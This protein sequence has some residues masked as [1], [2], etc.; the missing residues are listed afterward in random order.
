MVA[1][2]DKNMM[3]EQLFRDNILS[4]IYNNFAYYF[5]YENLYQYVIWLMVI[6]L[7]N[8]A[9]VKICFAGSY[10]SFIP[11]K[12]Y[13]FAGKNGKNML[14]F[15]LLAISLGAYCVCLFCTEK[16]IFSSFDSMSQDFVETM[17]QGTKA[18]F[19]EWRFTPLQAFDYN[20]MFGISNNY[21]VL[22]CYAVLKQVI[23]MGVLYKLLMFIPTVTRLV[24]LSVINFVPAVFWI[25]SA[26]FPEQNIIIFTVLSLL[27]LIEYQKEQ[28][29]RYLLYFLL[30]MNV[31]MYSK[32]T[33]ILFYLGLII[34]L[35]VAAIVEEKITIDAFWHPI[36]T[37][38]QFPLEYLMF[39]SM[40]LYA[41]GFMIFTVYGTMEN[42][43]IDTHVYP[44]IEVIK[45]Y[46]IELFVVLA[47]VGIMF[48]KI[49]CGKQMFLL[50]EGSVIG[51]AIVTF[52]IVFYMQICPTSDCFL[53]YY[54][55]LPVVFCVSYIFANCGNWKVL[56][57]VAVLITVVSG[58]I[59]YNTY[60]LRQG[61]D[62]LAM[63]EVIAAKAGDETVV[64]LYSSKSKDY[65]W[66]TMESW[67]AALKYLVPD[68]KLKFKSDALWDLRQYV[69]ENYVRPET[70]IGK[71]E[72]G[73]YILVNKIDNPEYAA[74]K[75]A[76]IVY[77]NKTYRLYLLKE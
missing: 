73:D 36:K 27:A 7:L 17:K 25:N 34:Y 62:R 74:Q 47:A 31:A 68:M 5:R 72:I 15:L 51:S 35:L 70:I 10:S 59:N 41:T 40:F 46:A 16:S 75:G 43:Y 49:S 6:L 54:L 69:N 77:E 11:N 42:R 24:C 48:Y 12:K 30:C 2:M 76:E 19:K 14:G 60:N 28:K 55:Y 53:S 50:K 29:S 71:P 1:E 39:V 13:I 67:A 38:R 21:T 66:W 33:V 37:L 20:I 63:A 26:I 45:C 22:G 23:I 32:E 65:K 3:T 58:A 18:V 64:F 61:Q 57:I 44:L 4:N 8:W 56:A 52:V 9:V